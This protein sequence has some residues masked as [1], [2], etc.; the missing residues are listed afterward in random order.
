MLLNKTAFYSASLEPA[1]NRHPHSVAPQIRQ[2]DGLDQMIDKKEISF[3]IVGEKGEV[4]GIF[5]ERN[6]GELTCSAQWERRQSEIPPGMAQ[7]VRQ[8]AAV[9]TRGI[10]ALRVLC[11]DRRMV[12][13]R[14]AGKLVEKYCSG[15]SFSQSTEAG[16][17]PPAPV[18]HRELIKATQE[19]FWELALAM[20]SSMGS[21][22][23]IKGMSAQLGDCLGNP[24]CGL[25]NLVKMVENGAPVRTWETQD[26]SAGAGPTPPEPV[27][28]R[29]EARQ[30]R[31]AVC[32]LLAE[33]ATDMISTS[34]PAGILLYVS[35]ACRSLLG[36][37]PEELAGHSVCEFVHADDLPAIKAAH[38]ALLCSGEPQTVSYRITRKDGQ[39]IWLETTSRTVQA[40]ET[41]EPVEIVAVSR[42]ITRR[43]RAE[44]ALRQSEARLESILN[45]LQDVVWSVAIDTNELVYLNPMAQTVYGRPTEEFFANPALWLDIVHPDD[46][47]LAVSSWQQL[48]ATGSK[49]M[50]CRIVWPSGEVRWLRDR[51]W[52]VRDSSGL[53][54]RI[55]G[56]TTDITQRV[57]MQE[58]LQVQT[59]H[60]TSLQARLQ[61]LL[62]SSP[63]AI[64]SA[65]A[66]GDF[67]TNFISASVTAML[68]YQ[69][70]QFTEDA[71]FW[72]RHIHPE[73]A[74]GVLAA[75]SEIVERECHTFDY[76]FLHANGTYRWVRDSV[77]LIRDGNGNPLEF[78]GSRADITA[79]KQAEEEICKALTREKELSQ[80][81]SRFITLTSHEFRTPLSAILSSADLLEFYL[82]KGAAQ[83]HLKHVERIQTAALHMTEMLNDILVMGRVE[84]GKL[85]CHPVPVDLE[86]ICRELVEAAA[87]RDGSKHPITFVSGGDFTG[88][89]MDAQ[90]LQ[91]IFGNLL[92]NAIDYSP[93]GSPIHF[94]LIAQDPAVGCRQSAALGSAP[95]GG[96][97]G[98]LKPGAEISGANPPVQVFS[99]TCHREGE[100]VAIF[101]IS[102][103]GTGIPV[104]DLPRVFECF[105]R[106]NNVGNKP[107]AGLGLAIVKKSVEAHGGSIAL[108]SHVGEGGLAGGTTVTVT[109]PLNLN[110]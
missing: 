92:C 56:L 43:K 8:E 90:L 108:E 33:N 22:C 12:A 1:I 88:A 48:L 85:D 4:L 27:R 60:A 44:E 103:S 64:Y 34:T 65:S 72:A 53:P 36:C 16:A 17:L 23:R 58:A 15:E 54:V 41:G 95:G 94:E 107:G 57:R 45:S 20:P 14:G 40:A 6:A 86:N 28:P 25:N 62:S 110:C 19:G 5:Y 29:E 37:E 24:K 61:H 3:L 99:E 80:L 89:C 74:A 52:V 98:N 83:K 82:E 49:D 47:P 106:G 67:A 66:S 50:E 75:L 55:D 84:S 71:S 30:D 91:Y 10:N 21:G 105:Y 93:E 7:P 76:R 73:D 81:R 70:R 69:P 35:P 109:L 63:V 68:G 78:V 18:F 11:C 13:V 102:D 100:K 77:R 51:A 2:K 39:C 59:A 97:F 46:R 9:G 101:R 32:Q 104:E 87:V 31:E 96:A 42:D 26:R 38:T 79:Q